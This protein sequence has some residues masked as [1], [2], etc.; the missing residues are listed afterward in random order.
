VRSG[1]PLLVAS[2]AFALGSAVGASGWGYPAGLAALLPLAAL[3]PLSPAAFGSAG[4]LAA[5]LAYRSP[6]AAPAA[7]VAVEGE[8][9]SV[10]TLFG[11]RSRF[12]L[13]TIPWGRLELTGA[14]PEWPL[15]LGDRVSLK[16]SL[17]T[18][19]AP[20]NP[21]GRDAAARLHAL[22]GCL[23]GA[24]TTPIVRVESPSPLAWLERARRRWA[25]A[26]AAL[27]EREAGILRA[28]GTGDRAGLDPAT[29]SAFARSGLAHVLAVS[30]LHLVVVAWGLFRLVAAGVLRM[31]G[32]A[33]RA[34]ARRIAAAVALPSTFVYALATGAGPPVIRAAIGAAA[35][36]LAVILRRELDALGALSIAALAVLALEPGA[37]LDPSLQLSFA[38]VA[39]LALGSDR[40]RSALPWPR[41][42]PGTWR[43]RIVE[44]FIEGGCAT[45]AAS[46][47]TAPIL[48]HHFRQLPLLGLLANVAAVP[49]GA[50]LTALGAVGA[51]LSAAWPP[52]ALPVVWVAWPF[53]RALLALAEGS[54]APAWGAIPLA[55]PA[56]GLS[57]A[58]GALALSTLRLTGW[59]RL[60]AV[61]SAAAC[62]ALSGP[63]RAEAA[64]RR[65][66][67][68]VIF[69]SVGQGDCALL[70][71]PDGSAV[72]VDGGGAPEGGA[73][74]GERDVVP[75]LR[76][77][78]VRR[79]AAVFASHPH[80]DHV[81]GLQAVARA[82]PIERLFTN[83]RAPF[84][85]SAEALSA[86]P[87]PIVLE[88]GDLWERSGVRFEL[89]GGDRRELVEN[90]ASLVFRVAFGPTAFVFP[91]DVEEAGEA[92]AANAGGL[93]SDVVKVAHHGSRRSST[94]PFVEATR[95]RFAVVSHGRGN[96]YGFPHAEALAR[97]REAGA[98]LVETVNGA[99]RFL[100]D[101]VRVRRVPAADVLDP[102]ALL[103]EGRALPVGS[104]AP[105]WE[106]P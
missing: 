106:R 65:G 70:R 95:P 30:G 57:I 20:R 87:S 37:I 42:A 80:P 64:R 93:R 28:I 66:G 32:L 19:A 16:A 44:P 26:T 94:S 9:A 62:L 55:R 96:R 17:R 3:P 68:E 8:V 92:A 50:T 21:G 72:L 41:P 27:P 97:W 103:R 82:F 91:G 24:G 14:E 75:L 85:Q 23:E 100:S 48:A 105:S 49:I 22:G 84:G 10:P 31:E 11:D 78:G 71:L 4:W 81:L 83:G 29:S 77:L 43:A 63:L 33:R 34:D 104:L 61:M 45:L 36:F 18:P 35:A 40:L 13:S 74:P 99:A 59:R 15:A 89:L 101:G 60:A 69:L 5:S 56:L 79:L 54:A 6:C 102:L 53:A 58:F 73:D 2:A 39:G 52:L 76:D 88:P 46:I 7:P 98:E 86:L 1:A 67:L 12:L 90:D 38:A 25:Q 47:A 51:L